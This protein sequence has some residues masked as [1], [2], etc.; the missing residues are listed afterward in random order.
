MNTQKPKISTKKLCDLITEEP[1]KEEKKYLIESNGALSCIESQSDGNLESSENKSTDNKKN[2]KPLQL[3]P[4]KIKDKSDSGSHSSNKSNTV[5]S[6]S[7]QN[8]KDEEKK[9]SA[10]ESF[11][12][13]DKNSDEDSDSSNSELSEDEEE[14]LRDN[15]ACIKYVMSLQHVFEREHISE[16]KKGELSQSESSLIDSEIEDANQNID[17]YLRDSIIKSFMIV[18]TSESSQHLLLNKDLI[19]IACNC[20]E[21]STEITTEA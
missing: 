6:V 2:K 7:S 8:K 17:N 12:T 14:F 11:K 15:V 19:E 5:L 3:S 20:M 9:E 18:F 13:D 21:Y 1:S 4:Q 10:L 16:T